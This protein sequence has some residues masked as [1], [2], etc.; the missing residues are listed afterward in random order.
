MKGK[1]IALTLLFVITVVLS[2]FGYLQAYDFNPEISN[3]KIINYGEHDHYE[4]IQIVLVVVDSL[5]FEFAK[6]IPYLQEMIDQHQGRAHLQK[7]HVAQPT[8]T[9]TNVKAILTGSNPFEYGKI[10]EMLI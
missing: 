4:P 6:R 9:V 3:T 8:Y 2:F 7:L 10:Y 1:Q 5:R